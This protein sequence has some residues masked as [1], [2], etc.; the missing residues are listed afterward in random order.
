MIKS[1]TG[2]GRCELVQGSRKALVEIKTVN[3][4]F[5]DITA[6]IPKQLN[7]MDGRIRDLVRQYLQRG[8]V[9]LY[10]SYE[11]N[12]DE[13]GSLCYNEKLASEYVWHIRKMSKEFGL[14]F[15]LTAESLS[16]CPHVLAM[17]ESPLD[18]EEA[19]GIV[20][21]ATVA[22]LEQVIAFRSEEGE[23]LKK[24]MLVKIACLQDMVGQVEERYPQVLEEYRQKLEGKMRELL[25][26]QGIDETRI[27]T[28]A[29]I[30]ADRICMD[31][32]LVRLKSHISSAIDALRE[33]D[34]VGRKLEFIVQEM[35]R[36]S[37]T[38]LSKSSD[39][40]VSKVGIEMRTEIEKLREQIQNIE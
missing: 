33:G 8:K 39:L 3:H 24:D 17:D 22:A 35:N 29:A 14:E 7:S 5:L 28:E 6:K 15:G 19:W 30:Y 31:E 20:H 11:D 23:R 40:A 21:Q 34:G 10:L 38:I 1:M 2:F 27:A 18:V 32:E 16:R 36:E 25:G 4:R 13:R 12:S 9:D 26:G 37:N